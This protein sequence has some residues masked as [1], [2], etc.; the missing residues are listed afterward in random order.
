MELH[1]LGRQYLQRAD[2]L[3]ERIHELNRYLKRKD[4]NDQLKLKH[5]ISALYSDAAECRRLAQILINYR[6]EDKT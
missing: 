2:I 6:R 5:R 1:E 4:A 3:T